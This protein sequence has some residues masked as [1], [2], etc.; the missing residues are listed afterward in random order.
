MKVFLRHVGTYNDRP[1]RNG[2]RLSM[3]AYARALD[4]TNF[5]LFDERDNLI[6]VS[7]HIRDYVDKNAVFYDEFR[8][9]WAESI[10]DSCDDQDF[11]TLALLATHALNLVAIAC[12][13]TIFIYPFPC[14][15][16]ARHEND[17]D[18]TILS[19]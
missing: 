7:T 14:V 2:Q 3:H 10:P 5:N 16:E 12:M 4:I 18:N 13:P 6:Q 15:P 1:V 8:Q 11:E 19:C 17:T 9:C